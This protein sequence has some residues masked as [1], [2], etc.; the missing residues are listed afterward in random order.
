MHD[1]RRLAACSVGEAK[2][3]KV[4]FLHLKD[5]R[6]LRAPDSDPEKNFQLFFAKRKN[7]AQN[8]DVCFTTYF[9]RMKL[10]E[11]VVAKKVSYKHCRAL[12]VV[13][14]IG[15][16][17]YARTQSRAHRCNCA[18]PSMCAESRTCALTQTTA[19]AHFNRSF[20]Q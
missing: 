11:E 18:R 19:E 20:F 13:S 3:R 14:V 4:T 12:V 10:S 6:L 8:D 9:Y 17:T 16:C 15:S 2:S 1:D 7:C 5:S